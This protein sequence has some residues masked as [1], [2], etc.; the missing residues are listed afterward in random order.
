MTPKF[1]NPIQLV[2]AI[3]Q[4]LSAA[5]AWLTVTGLED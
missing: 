4:S 2:E 1:T 3:L 5:E